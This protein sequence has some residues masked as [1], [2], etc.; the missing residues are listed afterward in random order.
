MNEIETKLDLEIAQLQLEH[1]RLHLEIMGRRE[2]M[3]AIEHR[4]AALCR[5][6]RNHIVAGVKP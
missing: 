6:K 1:R 5:E 4:I 2:R 3:L